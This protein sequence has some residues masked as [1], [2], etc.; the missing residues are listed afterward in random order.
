MWRYMSDEL[1]PSMIPEKAIGFLYLIKHTPSGKKYI[2]KKL[3]TKAAT[4]MVNGKKKKIRKP[5]DWENYWSSSPELLRFIESEGQDKFTRT[6][7]VFAETKGELN[8]LE[9][10]AQYRLH[11]LESDDWFNSNIRSRIFKKNVSK[12][13]NLKRLDMVC[14]IYR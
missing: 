3:L 11:V 1:D 2:G 10:A 5:S 9:E 7:L 13:K 14:N 4:K 12:Y 8:Y 6:I